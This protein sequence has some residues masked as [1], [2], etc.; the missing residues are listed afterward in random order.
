MKSTPCKTGYFSYGKGNAQAFD[1]SVKNYLRKISEDSILTAK[2]EIALGKKI[3]EGDKESRK[4]LIQSNL[5]LV[6]SIAKKYSG[7]GFACIFFCF[8]FEFCVF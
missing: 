2:E 1:D 5:R 4:K 7:Y 3:K 6:A 8:P